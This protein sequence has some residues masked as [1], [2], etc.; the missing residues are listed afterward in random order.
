[1]EDVVKN[2]EGICLP[3]IRL[4]IQKVVGYNANLNAVYLYLY[5]TRYGHQKNQKNNKAQRWTY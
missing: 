2:T 4:V 1:M 5:L 3:I